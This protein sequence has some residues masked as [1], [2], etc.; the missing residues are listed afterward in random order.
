PGGGGGPGGQADAA[1]RQVDARSLPTRSP[2]DA[3]AA[4]FAPARRS[5]GRRATPPAQAK[6]PP[7]EMDARF[8]PAPS[9][10][11][12]APRPHLPPAALA[13]RRRER[14][15]RRRPRRDIGGNPL[16][17]KEY[18]RRRRAIEQQLQEDLELIRAASQAKLRALEQLWLAPAGED[19]PDAASVTPASVEAQVVREEALETVTVPHQDP[20]S[21]AP[22]P[23]RHRGD[24]LADILEFFAR[25]PDV[26]DNRDVVPPPGY[27]PTR[28]SLH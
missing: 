2:P 16:Q 26:S 18:Q 21:P 28:P 12:Q 3:L 5:P 7:P 8:A 9:P 14:Y 19:P 24:V 1:P 22:A 23:V 20:I 15:P 25:L 13:R 6:R 27:E 11:L 10:F 4:R 17:H